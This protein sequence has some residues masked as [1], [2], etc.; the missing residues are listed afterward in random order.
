MYDELRDEIT[1]YLCD[2]KTDMES[3]LNYV[4]SEIG[5][6]ESTEKAAEVVEDVMH[7][8]MTVAYYMATLFEDSEPAQGPTDIFAGS[9]TAKPDRAPL[10]AADW[11]H[12]GRQIF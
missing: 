1:T 5:T 6:A 8:L 10:A 7:R 11:P 2:I 4:V 3:Y 12:N 9:G